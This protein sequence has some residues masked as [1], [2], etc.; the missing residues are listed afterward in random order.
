MFLAA[1]S[2]TN[3][4]SM[5]SSAADVGGQVGARKRGR[6]R[7]FVT[8]ARVEGQAEQ[9]VASSA[10]SR[11]GRG[12]PRNVPPEDAVS[13]Q[14]LIGNENDEQPPADSDEFADAREGS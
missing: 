10:P 14:K 12:R 7:K 8:P 9:A 5:N 1:P 2:L 13:N 3:S 6:P 11:R 4:S